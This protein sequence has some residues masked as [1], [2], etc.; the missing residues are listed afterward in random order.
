M[1]ESGSDRDDSEGYDENPNPYGSKMLE[2]KVGGD[3]DK[4]IGNVE[5]R[6]GNVIL[7]SMKSKVLLKA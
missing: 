1:Y 6:Q 3:F 4:N 7:E 5:Y 2:S